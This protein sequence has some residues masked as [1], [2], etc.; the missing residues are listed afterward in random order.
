MI[1]IG[2]LA[3]QGAVEPHRLHIEALGAKFLAVRNRE[4]LE[5]ADGI[6]LPGGESS[7][8]LKILSV[9]GL[10][11][12]LAQFLK[13][14]PSW[15]ICAGAILMAREVHCPAQK[16]FGAFDVVIERNA[17]GRQLESFNF[18]INGAE[19]AF[20]RAPQITQVG[21]SAHIEASVDQKPVWLTDGKN[22]ITTFHPE[23][24]RKA[25]SPMHKMFYNQI[26][27]FRAKDLHPEFS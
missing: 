2:V 27:N 4:H 1:T 7:T 17:Y 6:I 10:E 14:K 24:S 20:I 21:N 25:P 15:G 26:V 18:E 5:Q 9:L 3:L 23:L 12:E 22:M 11:N 16:S 19:V 13:T 8:M